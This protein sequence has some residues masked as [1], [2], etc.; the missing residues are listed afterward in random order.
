MKN[1]ILLRLECGHKIELD[2]RPNPRKVWPDPQFCETDKKKKRVVEINS[3]TETCIRDT[4]PTAP[5][6]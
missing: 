3:K 4:S 1:K 5:K 6:A 2:S